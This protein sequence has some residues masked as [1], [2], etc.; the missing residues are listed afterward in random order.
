[1]KTPSHFDDSG[2]LRMTDVADKEITRRKAVATATVRLGSE[3]FDLLRSGRVAKGDVLTTA[4]LAGIQAAKRT[5]EWIPLCHPI[6]IQHVDVKCRL[7]DSAPEVEIVAT[8]AARWYTGVEME[9]LT[10]VAAAALTVYDMCKGVD[11]GIVVR[12]IGLLSKT[13]GKSGDW[14]R[15]L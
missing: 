8:A 4:R 12:E 9:A 11:R 1:M 10:A 15:K 13:G 2:S 7:A 6:P 3:A 14:N 5:A